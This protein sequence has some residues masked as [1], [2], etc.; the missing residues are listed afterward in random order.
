M[1]HVQPSIREIGR[2]AIQLTPTTQRVRCD[3]EWQQETRDTAP[4][5]F[6]FYRG[7][8]ALY[9]LLRS[10]KIGTGDEVIVQAFTCPEVVQPILRLGAIP[11]FCDTEADGFGLDSRSLSRAL[12]GATKAVLIQ[13]TFGVPANM[14]ALMP[15]LRESGVFVIEDCCHVC[16]SE[17]DGRPVGSFGDAAFYSYGPEKPI[18]AGLGGEAVLNF[19]ALARDFQSLYATCIMPS[20]SEEIWA[21]IRIA[22]KAVLPAEIVV[23]FR[24]ALRGRGLRTRNNGSPQEW[25]DRECDRRLPRVAEFRVDRLLARAD[26]ILAEKRLTIQRVADGISALGLRRAVI[27]ERCSAVLWRYPILV[28]DKPKLLDRARRCAVEI[29]DWGTAPFSC[30]GDSAHEHDYYR[31]ACPNAR[32]LSDIVVTVPI[33]DGLS[34]ARIERL[35]RFLTRMKK[36][37]IA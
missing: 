22:A 29:L 20:F 2:R 25:S 30:S 1:T 36:E 4:R 27:P 21:V 17:Y 11:V 9:C 15:I 19:P 13:H 18:A 28:R 5:H 26:R 34:K 32:K 8:I 10:Q 35:T 31:R 12:T 7:R 3:C 14:N 24:D 33:Y 37:G 6:R 16:A 23:M